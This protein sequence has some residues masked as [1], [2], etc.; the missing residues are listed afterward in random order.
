[1]KAQL[2]IRRPRRP[3]ESDSDDIYTNPGPESVASVSQFPMDPALL[4]NS[5]A[6]ET[7][8]IHAPL[9]DTSHSIAYAF[10]NSSID[11]F[12]NLIRHLHQSND[13]DK[14]I[15]TQLTVLFASNSNP[16]ALVPILFQI[17]QTENQIRKILAIQSLKVLSINNENISNA[18]LSRL[19]EL[20]VYKNDQIVVE[21]LQLLQEIAPYANENQARKIVEYASQNIT[22][23]DNNILDL[24]YSVL[25]LVSNYGSVF[26]SEVVERICKMLNY[27]GRSPIRASVVWPCLKSCEAFLEQQD[28]AAYRAFSSDKKS[29]LILKLAHAA[30]LAEKHEDNELV[31]GVLR[32]FQAAIDEFGIT[33]VASFTNEYYLQLDS[34]LL[35]M[36]KC[37]DEEKKRVAEAVLYRLRLIKEI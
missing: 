34:V 36:M 7:D 35:E 2:D 19:D 11:P 22:S 12:S 14:R 20:I 29:R 25:S 37:D 5:T 3:G 18:T 1:M 10:T 6:V 31:L 4:L 13:P 32:L 26:P 16:V 8:P 17:L 30:I 21:V 24:V 28:T 9:V 23:C 27:P 33:D 15:F